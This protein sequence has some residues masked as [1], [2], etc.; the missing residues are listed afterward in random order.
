LAL[1]CS[2]DGAAVTVD[3]KSVGNTPIMQQALMSG[4]HTV[5]VKKL[6]FLDFIEKLEIE[7]GK[8]VRLAA[9]LLPVAGVIRVTANVSNARVAVDGKRLGKTP[10][11]REVKI[12]RRTVTVTAPGYSP[13]SET[14]SADP[15]NVYEIVADLDEAPGAGD[16]LAAAPHSGAGAGEELLLTALPELAPPGSGGESLELTALAPIPGGV[17]MRAGDVG[18]TVEEETPWYLEWWVLTAAAAVATG[19]V[20][21][22]VALTGGEQHQPVCYHAEWA[23]GLRFSGWSHACR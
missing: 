21:T 16:D 10:L 13:Y 15:G 18:T 5:V 14:I 11:E 4:T 12:G 22:T 1:T 20:V 7:P 3:G 2:V 8:T 23:P 9:N 17:P 19:A 6:G